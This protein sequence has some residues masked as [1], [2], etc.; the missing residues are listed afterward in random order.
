MVRPYT[1]KTGKPMGFVTIEDIQGNIELVLFPKTWTKTR[2]V[3]GADHYCRRQSGYQQ[4]AA[5]DP[6]RR[7]PDRRRCGLCK[8]GRGRLN[9]GRERLSHSED[10]RNSE[11]T[12]PR[13]FLAEAPNQV[14]PSP[15]TDERS[16]PLRKSGRRRPRETPGGGAGPQQS[17]SARSGRMARCRLRPTISLA[18]GRRSGSHPLT[19]L[20]WRGGQTHPARPHPPRTSWKTFPRRRRA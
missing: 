19:M 8:V 7:Y 10:Q 12:R 4:Y 1:T 3:G 15:R 9:P 6:C 14:P 2:D 16:G 11:D 20:P 17:G 18:T 13:E 5:E